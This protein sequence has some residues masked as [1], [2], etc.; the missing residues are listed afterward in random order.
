MKYP[1]IAKENGIQGSV[2]ASFTVE[3]DG[4]ISNPK[5]EKGIDPSLDKEAIRVINAIPKST[6]FTETEDGEAVVV[7]YTLPFNFS[8]TGKEISSDYSVIGFKAEATEDS[9]K[10]I[11]VGSGSMKDKPVETLA[12]KFG[13]D[14]PIYIVDGER[15]KEIDNIDPKDI[16]SISVLKNESAISKY[17]DEGKNGVIEVTTKSAITKSALKDTAK[18]KLRISPEEIFVVVEDQPQFT[19]GTKALM[20]YLRDNIKY[21]KESHEKKIEGRVI[22]NFV[23]NTDGSISDVS[24]IRGIDPMLDAEAMRVISEMPNWKPGM[25]R[26]E[27]VRVRFTLP[28]VYRLRDEEKT[29]KDP[30]DELKGTI[31]EV[32]VE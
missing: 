7:R 17:G 23:V 22:V 14:K 25:Q 16:E 29:E 4:S 12:E 27:A 15:T 10:V 26:G 18:D 9:N 5:I 19:G 32:R 31:K 13:A 11:V 20:Q 8:L 3:K 21:P 2:L 1:Q 28:I 30:L 6:P 24:V